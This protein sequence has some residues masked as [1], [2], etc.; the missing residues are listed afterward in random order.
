[1]I[2]VLGSV[3]IATFLVRLP[4]MRQYGKN[5]AAIDMPMSQEPTTDRRSGSPPAAEAMHV[6]GSIRRKRQV[7]GVQDASH[8]VDRRDATVGNGKPLVR[9]GVISLRSD[10]AKIAVVTNKRLARIVQLTF[11]LQVDEGSHARVKKRLQSGEIFRL[12][13]PP[14]IRT[15]EQF[16]LDD[17]MVGP[18]GVRVSG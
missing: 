15:C 14:R 4:Q 1:L 5:I 3:P 12:G 8:A 18:A 7:D 17:P 13:R 10:V 2:G 11:F 16:V 6:V 9:D